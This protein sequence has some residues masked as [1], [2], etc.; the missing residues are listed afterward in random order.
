MKLQIKKDKFIDE[1]GRQVLLRG[2]NL[3]GSTKVPV[4]PNGATHIKTDFSDHKEVSYI[5]HP[6]SLEEADEHLTRLKEWGY[7][8]LRF[9]V[10]WEAIEHKGPKSYD[11]EYLSYLRKVLEIVNEYEFYTFIDPHQDVWSRMTGGDGAPGWTFEKVGLDFTKFAETEAAI[12]MQ[13]HYPERYPKM[14]WSTNYYR[15]ASSTMFSLFFGGNKVAPGFTIGKQSIQDYLQEHYMNSIKEVAKICKDLPYVIGFDIFNEPNKG[16]LC[17]QDLTFRSDIVMGL[18]FNPFETMATASGHTMAIPKYIPRGVMM[19]KAGNEIVN[20]N[21]I[22]CWLPG[23]KD[24]WRE[25]GIWEENKN[26]EPKLLKPNYFVDGKESGFFYGYLKEF[27]NKYSQAIKEVKPEAMIFIE[28]DPYETIATNKSSMSDNKWTKNDATN[29]VNASHWYD[30]FTL[31]VQ[32][33]I[34][35]L[36]YDTQ[37]KKL[38]LFGKN[39]KETFINQL[40]FIKNFSKTLN[41]CPTLIGE[42]GIP[43]NMLNKKAFRTGN[44]KKHIDALTLHVDCMDANLLNYTLWNYT[45]DNCNDWG[46][47]WNL[48]DLSIFSRDQQDNTSDLNSGGR[49]VEGFCRPYVVRTPGELLSM[50]FKRRKGIFTFIIDLD[51]NIKEPIELFIPKIQFPNGYKINSLTGKFSTDVD[52]QKLFIYQEENGKANFQITRVD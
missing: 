11:K 4:T 2:V 17:N 41:N 20:P 21:G 16:Y 24:I 28:S 49:A 22:N 25:L 12:T 3:G 51:D 19:F 33:F 43:F 13:T 34:K 50:Q 23:A 7:N 38:L 30:G 31:Y 37:K 47:L 46:D 14:I 44:W 36:S 1:K 40:K 9:L 42:F 18:R 6:F 29:L 39:I 52:N 27:I 48:E 15:F 5:G 8:C 45:A 10:T 35:F 32:R 26:G